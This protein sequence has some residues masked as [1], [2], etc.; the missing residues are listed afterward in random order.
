MKKFRIGLVI[1]LLIGIIGV[2]V[3]EKSEKKNIIFAASS[4][5]YDSKHH[6]IAIHTDLDKEYNILVIPLKERDDYLDFFSEYLNENV[7]VIEGGVISI[8]RFN[9]SF[10][11]SPHRNS[12]STHISISLDKPVEEGEMKRGFSADCGFDDVK[13]RSALQYGAIKDYFKIQINAPITGHVTTMTVRSIW[14]DEPGP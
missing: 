11:S 12:K 1:L 5:D 6:R 4:F 10:L 14:S 8:E 7:N 3:Y 9:L 2:V 13:W